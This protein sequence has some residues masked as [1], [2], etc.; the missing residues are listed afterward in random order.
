MRNVATRQVFFHNGPFKTLR[1]AV[2]F[3]GHRNTHP[4]EFY[5]RDADGTLMKFADLPRDLQ[6]NVNTGEVA[7]ERRLGQAPRFDEAEIDDLIAFQESL[8][9]GCDPATDT[10][11]SARNVPAAL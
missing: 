9:D 8:T 2:H 6:R 1:D 7:Y 10:A 3:C 4:E 11:D 5:P